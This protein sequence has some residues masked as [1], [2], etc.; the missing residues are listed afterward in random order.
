MI[1]VGLSE[2]TKPKLFAYFSSK[3]LIL[4]KSSFQKDINILYPLN[5]IMMHIK[6]QIYFDYTRLNNTTYPFCETSEELF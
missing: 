2:D 1:V 3:D 5:L 4:I 6:F